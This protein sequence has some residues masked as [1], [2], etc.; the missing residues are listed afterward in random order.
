[1]GHFRAMMISLGVQQ[2]R[3]PPLYFLQA[4]SWLVRSTEESFGKF[5]EEAGGFLRLR[6]PIGSADFAFP[7]GKFHN[8]HHSW[9][10]QGSG[11]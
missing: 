9:E 5:T 4:S 2:D 11:F 1:M 10:A 8:D 3:F 6:L 7:E